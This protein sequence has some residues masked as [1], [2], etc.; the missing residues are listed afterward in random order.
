LNKSRVEEVADW[1]VER[2]KDVVAGWR[3]EGRK[4][5]LVTGWKSRRA[6]KR[7]QSFD[8]LKHCARK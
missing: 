8:P 2:G 7:N 6:E 3:E 4:K 1:K 5:K